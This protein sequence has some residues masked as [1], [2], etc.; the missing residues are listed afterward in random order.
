MSRAGSNKQEAFQT[1]GQSSWAAEILE[2]E[3]QESEEVRLLG[4][5]PPPPLRLTPSWWPEPPREKPQLRGSVA[6]DKA[7]AWSLLSKSK[8][9]PPKARLVHVLVHALMGDRGGGRRRSV[10]SQHGP[11][12][13]LCGPARS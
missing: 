4:P 6:A 2:G 8:N 1:E 11:V 7:K 9:H 5:S 12:L 3:G 10:V 13:S